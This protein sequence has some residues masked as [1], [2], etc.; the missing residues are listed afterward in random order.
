MMKRIKLFVIALVAMCGFSACE[1]DCDHNFIE[2]DYN[3]ELVG[4]WTTHSAYYSEAL[5]I[6]A[7]G[8]VV[9][10]GIENGEYW[11]EVKGSIKTVNNKMTM[12]F[13][14]GDNYEGRFEMICGEAFTIIGENGEHFTFKLFNINIA[15]MHF[16]LFN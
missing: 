7:D 14:D 4:T 12:T 13:E 8:S 5:V 11:E 10:T 3:K 16:L 1:K 9:S 15:L 2:V 6:S